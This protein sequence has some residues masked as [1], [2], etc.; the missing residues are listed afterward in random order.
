ML[1]DVQPTDVTTDIGTTITFGITASGDELKY[2]WQTS[3]DEG[4]TWFDTQ[5]KGYD[6]NTLTVLA[7]AELN[8]NKFRCIVSDINDVSEISDVVTLTV[9][10]NIFINDTNFPDEVF[11]NYVSDNFD[12]DSDGTLSPE[13]V[14]NATFVD[15][16]NTGCTS[17]DGI[18]LLSAVEIIYCSENSFE[19]IDVSGCQN[20]INLQ[21]SYNELSRLDVSGCQDLQ[22]LN[23]CCNLLTSIDV[24]DCKSLKYLNCGD[25]AL[26]SLDVTNCQ[27]LEE[28]SCGENIL[29]SLYM[30]ENQP[31]RH[32]RCTANILT[33]LNVSV[34]QA[35]EDLD[36]SWNN[37]TN[38]DI[39]GCKSLKILKCFRNNLLSLDISECTEL[40]DLDCSNNKLSR[41]DISNCESLCTAYVAKP[42]EPGH[43][44][45]ETEYLDEE[46]QKIWYRLVFDPNVRIVSG[47]P[48]SIDT[49]PVDITTIAG[50]TVTFGITATG[51]ELT[52]Q[53]QTSKDNGETW[54]DSKMTG[55]N[56]DTLTVSAA[57]SRNGYQF[58]CVVTDKYGETAISD[59]ATLTITAPI[60]ITAQPQDITTE[61]GKTVKFSI[62]ATGIGLKYQWQTSKDKGATWL[63]SKMTGYNTNTLTVSAAI[64]RNG[65][66]FRCVVTDASGKIITSN[67]ATLTIKS[68]VELK[69]TAHP[70]DVTTP[71]GANV[72]FKITAQGD[73][74]KYQWQASKDGGKNWTNSSMTGNK[75]N[76]LTVSA[77]ASRNGYK[78][79]CIVTDSTGKT[80]TSNA[81]TL[82]IGSATEL[83]ITAQPAD[84]TTPAGK[85]VTFSITVTG[86]GL[87]Y[88]WQTSKDGGKN[89]VNS[90]MSGYNTNTL[91]VSA[92][93]DRNG[94]KFRCVVTDKCGGSVTSEA[95]TLIIGAST[96]TK[97]TGQPQDVTTAAGTTVTFSITATGTGL[98]YQWQTSKDG[99][100]NWINSGM[101]GYN[102]NTLT[103]SAIADRNGY[104]FRCVV[105]D[106]SGGSIISE[107]ATLIIG[108]GTTTE[109][110]ITSQPDDV[111]TADGTTVKFSVTVEGTGLKYQWQT[112][113]DGG[114]SWVDSG[115]TGYNTNTLTVSAITARNGYKFRCVVTD[116]N[117]TKVISNAAT[118]II[119][120]GTTT[121]LKITSQPADITTADGTTVKFSVTAEGTGLKY[122]WQTSKDGG[123]TW[124]NS[125]MTGYNTNTLTVSAIADRNGY[126]FR[127][128]VT[129]KNGNTATS[130]GA[131]LSV[132]K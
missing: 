16:K 79:R 47:N 130:N 57:I 10:A 126:Q 76:T 85:D 104:K 75:T 92:I 125:G 116:K 8:G 34:Y 9:T 119:G 95:A 71:A 89:W 60:E 121:E 35:L 115:M 108:S 65:Y 23:C 6:T 111:T 107:A 123:K 13:E 128:I 55:Y 90:G 63:D 36:C 25:N 37:I 31:L 129:D 105:T 67:A 113:K 51:D 18:K 15:L 99:G 68:A 7:K 59:A 30:S 58:R 2:Q 62:T 41:L 44:E 64:S 29:T 78:F 106:K 5:I 101:S 20:L 22:F 38:L 120:S 1:I 127:C 100:N 73:G 94:Y 42:T 131:K 26:T 40:I 70:E 112:S 21:C 109:L 28:L 43:Y 69:I 80:V 118:L 11:R 45:F 103:V 48:I 49:Q 53:W 14:S 82:I 50:A 96:D 61:A 102:T 46:G 98:K 77:V 66:Q 110:K 54:I 114:S 24:S 39:S 93:A 91:T 86:V 87:K 56:T 4:N 17:L 84:V 33:E 122:Q 27:S 74:L 12:N 3:I 83:K 97:I 52:Y 32:L 124:V 132:T 81:A 88:Q 72:T 117:G 19:S